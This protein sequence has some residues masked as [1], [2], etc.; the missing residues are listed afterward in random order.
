VDNEQAPERRHAVPEIARRL[1]VLNRIRGLMRADRA[2]RDAAG[3]Q[4]EGRSVE[5]ARTTTDRRRPVDDISEAELARLEAEARYHRERLALYRAKAYGPRP[6]SLTRLRE[7]ER[8]SAGAQA[9]LEQA[10]TRRGARP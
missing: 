7:L 5:E 9:R 1:R 6:T 2:R 10:H 3:L 8:T 4:G